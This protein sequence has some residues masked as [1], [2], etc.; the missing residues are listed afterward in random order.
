MPRQ[1]SPEFRQRALRLLDTMMEGSEDLWC[2]LFG[3]RTG[4]P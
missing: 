2:M 1:Y 3:D 4:R